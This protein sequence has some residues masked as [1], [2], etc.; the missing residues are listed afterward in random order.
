M[1]T[2]IDDMLHM[3]DSPYPAIRARALLLLGHEQQMLPLGRLT[4]LYDDG[5]SE[6][7]V[8]VLKYLARNLPPGHTQLAF[9]ALMDSANS[10]RLTA[11]QY[12]TTFP[13]VN[14]APILETLLK[15]PD[16]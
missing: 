8:A 4:Q 14:A 1:Q 6:I 15:N 10:V 3:L 5:D 9:K 2:R 13:N 12:V 11:V 16:F 7:R